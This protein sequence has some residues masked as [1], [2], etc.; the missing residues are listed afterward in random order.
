MPRKKKETPLRKKAFN[1]SNDL[2]RQWLIS[3]GYTNI[4]L[5]RHDTRHP[6]TVWLKREPTESGKMHMVKY[7]AVDLWNLFDGICFD[8]AGAPIYLQIKTDGW[9]NNKQMEHFLEDKQLFM[10]LAINIKTRIKNG[11]KIET[12]SWEK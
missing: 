2:A 5:K 4:W 12:R 9:P 7:K 1:K 6:D 3:N 10:A 11:P 8:E